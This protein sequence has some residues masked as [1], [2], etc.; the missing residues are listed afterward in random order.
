VRVYFLSLWTAL[1]MGSCQDTAAYKRTIREQQVQI[2]EL[3]ERID[4]LES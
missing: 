2:E 3:L 1:M 4:E